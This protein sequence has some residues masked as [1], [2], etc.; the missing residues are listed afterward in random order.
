M[1]SPRGLADGDQLAHLRS[2][3]RQRYSADDPET[4]TTGSTTGPALPTSTSASEGRL[5]GWTK[6][7]PDHRH[8]MLLCQFSRLFLVAVTSLGLTVGLRFDPPN[9]PFTKGVRDSHL[10]HCVIGPHRCTCQM[11]SKSVEGDEC[12]RRQTDHATEK[13]INRSD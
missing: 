2:G 6:H 5:Q 8:R 7:H 4:R 12:D 1:F 10:T 3:Q 11:A 13:S 9:L